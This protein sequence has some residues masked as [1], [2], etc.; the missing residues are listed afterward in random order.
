MLIISLC[1]HLLHSSHFYCHFSKNPCTFCKNYL[2]FLPKFFN[3]IIFAKILYFWQ[4]IISLGQIARRLDCASR[5]LSKNNQNIYTKDTRS[6]SQANSDKMYLSN[7]RKQSNQTL[8]LATKK[9]FLLAL[10]I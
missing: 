7:N 2:E 10:V 5:L 9:G 8:F 6:I 3:L 1:S 4:K